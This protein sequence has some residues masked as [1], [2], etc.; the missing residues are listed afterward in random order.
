MAARTASQRVATQVSQAAQSLSPIF[1]GFGEADESTRVRNTEL[2][3][4]R[5]NFTYINVSNPIIVC[6][7]SG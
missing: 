2:Q 1:A 6:I 3:R 4:L 7:D 5:L